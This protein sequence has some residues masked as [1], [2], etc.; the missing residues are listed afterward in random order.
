MHITCSIAPRMLK[1]SMFLRNFPDLIYAKS[2][3]SY[4]RNFIKLADDSCTFIPS[5][6]LIIITFISSIWVLVISLVVMIK[7]IWFS[8]WYKFSFSTFYAMIEFK[9][10][11]S[12]C[13]TQALIR[14]SNS[15]WSFYWS[16]EMLS[17]MSIICRMVRKPK[18][19]W[20]HCVP[21]IF[22]YLTFLSLVWLDC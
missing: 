6:S 16:Y 12:S 9:G 11:L 1:L 4:T 13:E 8:W 19:F 7:K 15:L 22:T 17:V 21:I 14:P 3:R 2:S 10:F 20:K 5:F 18:P